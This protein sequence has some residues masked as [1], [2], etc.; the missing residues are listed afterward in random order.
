MHIVELT[1]EELGDICHALLL[2]GTQ[3]LL[4]KT[5]GGAINY[6]NM[7]KLYDMLSPLRDKGVNHGTV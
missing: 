6:N 1:T 3:Y 7:S 2:T 5:Q 4:H